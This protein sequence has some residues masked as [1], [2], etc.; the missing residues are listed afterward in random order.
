MET[1]LPADLP[2][3]FCQPAAPEDIKLSD[4]I[5]N[6]SLTF[7]F[8]WTSE[9]LHALT[10]R[11]FQLGYVKIFVSNTAHGLSVVTDAAG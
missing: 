4:D 8:D 7:C 10:R 1:D 3:N 11:M 9:F 6:I 2:W 5:T